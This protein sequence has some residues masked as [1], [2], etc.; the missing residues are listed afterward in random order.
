M[1]VLALDTTTRRGSCA[2]VQDGRVLREDISDPERAHTTRLPADLMVLLARTDLRLSD[3]D[4]FAVAIGPGSFTGL[5]IGIAAMQ[6][7]AFATRRPLIGIS[8]LDA[9]ASV[10]GGEQVTTWV[11][12]W[13]G[14]VYASRY[15]NGMA[16]ASPVVSHPDDLLRDIDSATTFVGD[17]TQTYREAIAQA[18]GS[19]A[20][21]HEPASPA[22]AATIGRLALEEAGRGHLPTPH[23]IRPLYVRRPEV[24]LT[25]EARRGR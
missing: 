17:A 25:R 18:L 1:L 24:E 5:R 4:V 2:V 14:E 7:L 22:L 11:D 12:A 8:T 10:A 20:S 3:I 19:R 21:F 15:Q 6:G 16:I 23:A 13:R 9:L